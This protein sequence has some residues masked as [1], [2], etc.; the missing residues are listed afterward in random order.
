MTEHDLNSLN[1]YQKYRLTKNPRYLNATILFCLA[2]IDLVVMLLQGVMGKSYSYQM[3]TAG[4]FMIFMALAVYQN[5][6]PHDLGR[7]LIQSILYGLVGIA[8]IIWGGQF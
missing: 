1:A 5:R 6:N 8:V 4:L 7:S 3:I 2:G